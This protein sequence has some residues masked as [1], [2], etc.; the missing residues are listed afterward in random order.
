MPGVTVETITRTGPSAFPTAPSGQFFAVGLAERGATDG[1]TLIRNLAEFQV[2]FGQ[3]VSYSELYDNVATF[4]EEGGARA[5]VTRVVGASATTG[6]VDVD[7]RHTP[8]SPTLKFAAANA[9]SWSDDL[10]IVVTELSSSTR[11]QVVLGGEVV[12]SFVGSTVE[13]IVSAF[14]DS[15]YVV[16]TSLGSTGVAPSNMPAAGTYSLSAGT[17]DRSNV[18]AADYE[19]ALALFDKSLGDGAVAIPGIGTTVHAYLIAHARDNNRIAL[20]SMGENAT[21][22]ALKTQADSLNSEFAGLFAPWVQIST[23]QGSRF[24]SPEGYVAAVRN[25]AHVEAGPW[26]APAGQ[27]AVARSVTGL[28][29]DYNRTTGDDLDDS[30]VNAIRIINNTIRLYGW[31][32]LSDDTAN[33]SLLIG[34]DVLNRIVTETERRLE[35]FVFQTID[36]RGLLFSAIG[37]TVVNILEPMR[38]GGGL[39]E[40]FDANGNQVD[41]GYLVDTSTAVNTL[42]NLANNE[43]KVKV[44]VRVSPVAALIS[45]TIVKVGLLSN[46]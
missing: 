2:F 41:P 12:E 43:V 39:Y 5:Y 32:S 22:A 24:T 34:R 14:A 23:P 44:S 19:D 42:D 3:R 10:D 45:V 37:G 11:V 31:R 46:L 9:G 15:R 25:R 26:R 27:I 33:Y 17:D 20:L 8:D 4:F 40:R 38:Q 36:G 13:E 35:D 29:F 30:K 28:K 6:Y 1:P 16:C 21:A 7:D 18:T